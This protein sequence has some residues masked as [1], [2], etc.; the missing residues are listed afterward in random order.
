MHSLPRRLPPRSQIRATGFDVPLIEVEAVDKAMTRIRL[1]LVEDDEDNL[2]VL[3]LML[4]EKYTVFGYASAVEAL[5]A[6]DAA[7]PDVLVLD[8]GMHPIDGMQCLKAIRATPGYSDIPAVA[9]TGFA[10]DVERQSFLDGGFQAVV[11]KPMLDSGELTAAIDRLVNSR[12][13]AGRATPLY[14]R[15]SSGVPAPSAAAADLD[16]RTA[17]TVSGA[18]ESGK[19]R[20]QA[21]A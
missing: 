20:G 19:T 17:M 8:I 14:Q 1:V 5:Q 11:V 9:L 3:S 2:E 10:R 4:G 18:G 16:G 6:I 7:K 15:R 13:P 21:P 12:G